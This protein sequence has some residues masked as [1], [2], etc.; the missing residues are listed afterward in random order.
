MGNWPFDDL[1]MNSSYGFA[2]GGGG[3]YSFRLY[4]TLAA[5]A[6]PVVTD[7][8]ILPW[9]DTRG[10]KWDECVIRIS[11]PELKSLRD[12]LL[13]I[14]PP[15]SQAFASRHAACAKLWDNLGV[16]EEIHGMWIQAKFWSEIR[17]RIE[18][19]RRK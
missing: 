12:V 18:T 9:E 5:G 4:E 7:D 6:I 3:P 14:A 16:V 8:M 11:E 2:P 17:G 10:V 15:G 1:L 19:A 13:A